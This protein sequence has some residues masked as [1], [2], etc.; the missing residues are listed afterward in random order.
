M[1]KTREKMQG[2]FL[3]ADDEAICKLLVDVESSHSLT[4]VAQEDCGFHDNG[5]GNHRCFFGVEN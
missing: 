1:N 4:V 5:L 3:A 2:Q